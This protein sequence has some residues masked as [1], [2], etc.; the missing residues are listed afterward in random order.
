VKTL[1]SGF[2][3][4][5]QA[6]VQTFNTCLAITRTDGA[7]FYFTDCDQPIVFGGHT[8]DPTDGYAPTQMQSSADLS[9]D[10]VEVLAYLKSGALLEADLM[11][12]K[13]D[14]AIVQMF[15]VNRKALAHGAY[16]MRYGVLGQVTITS[17]GQY[18]AELRGIAQWMQKQIGQLIS[19]TCRWTLGDLGSGGAIAGSHCTVNLPALAGSYSVTSVT[20]NQAFHASSL[21]QPDGYYTMGFLTWTSG[22]NNGRSMDIQAYALTGGS[23]VLQ[24]PML[25]NIVIGDAFTIYPGCRKRKVEDCIN[26]FNNVINF[27]GFAE[28]PGI[29]SMLRPG[30][31]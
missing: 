2:I 20:N 26:K 25:N 13:W 19:P 29:D 3:A 9:V 1:S 14:D 30:G 12:G 10:H 7:A 6:G 23:V 28:L 17:P 8:Y 16:Q 4:D 22:L 11:A 27:G 5:L 15:M 31:V 21:A 18:Q 24:L